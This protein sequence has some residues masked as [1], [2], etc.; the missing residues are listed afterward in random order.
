MRVGAARGRNEGAG[1]R[2]VVAGDEDVVGVVVGTTGVRGEVKGAE[3]V[4]R[5]ECAIPC[6]VPPGA[7]GCRPP[8]GP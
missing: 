2:Y 7:P 5:M 4:D 6:S 3:N 8:P 1:G